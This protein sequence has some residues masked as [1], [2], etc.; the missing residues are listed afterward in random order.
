MAL[1]VNSARAT[2]AKRGGGDDRRERVVAALAEVCGLDAA[3]LARARTVAERARQPVEQTLSQ[4]GVVSD[5]A[6]ANAY[7]RV[8]GCASCPEGELRS[9]V[10][11]AELPLSAEFLRKRRLLPI[12]R[13]ASR[14]VVAAC[15]PL[16]DE[17]LAGLVFASG[18]DLEIRVATPSAW[19]A[20]FDAWSPPA[21]SEVRLDE[22]RLDLDVQLVTDTGRDSDAARLLATTLEAAHTR[23]ASDIHF[24]PRRFD[25]RI[26]LRVDGQLVDHET[27]SADLAASVVSR[28]KVLANLD[29][30][31]R[32]L[33]QDG[34]ATFVVGGKPVDARVSTAPSAF[35][36]AAVLRLLDR[37]AVPLDLASLGFGGRHQGVLEV[38]ARAPHGIFLVTGP[39]GSGKTT[40]LYTVLN[41]FARSQK[42]I[43]SIEDPIEYHF[44]HVVQTQAAPAIGLTFATALRSFLRQ[45]P[46]VILVGEIRDAETAQVAIQAALTGHLVLASLHA[47]DA[48]RVAPRLLDMGVEPYQLAAAFLGAL[49][50][51]LV[52]RLCPHCRSER[53]T[54]GPELRFLECCGEPAAGTTFEATGCPQCDAGYRG[55]VALAEGFAANDAF[56]TALARNEPLARL[57]ALAEATGLA[58]M[59]RDGCQKAGAGLTTLREVMAA[60]GP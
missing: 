38:A 36:E 11:P 12:E 7:A 33:P 14:L 8:S 55:R 20:A 26:R 34:R 1:A 9:S 25:L 31:E 56:S 58:P 47:N 30:G 19:R 24:E 59:R 57:Q 49:A 3:T 41:A 6:L 2:A 52:R 4:M 17:G 10:D 27:A 37:T 46:D 39:T 60:C 32:R 29:L 15:D 5:Q 48:V 53:P 43:L 16:D 51:R 44:G 40:T 22:R 45:D 42:K 13:R 21:D 35:G 28:V 54:T 18:L 50:Q 23:A